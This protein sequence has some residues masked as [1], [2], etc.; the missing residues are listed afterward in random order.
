MGQA[1]ALWDELL[2]ESRK[3]V[4]RAILGLIAVVLVAAAAYAKSQQDNDVSVPVVVAACLV[5]LIIGPVAGF[6]VGRRRTPS[7]P[8]SPESDR[9][10][11]EVTRMAR[12][13]EVYAAHIIQ[14][15]STI[16]ELESGGLGEVR[17]NDF[18][19]KGILEPA[20]DALIDEAGEDVRV[21]V[22]TPSEDEPAD[23]I[24]RWA[25]GH[26]IQGRQNYQ[27]P[28]GE[29]FAGIAYRTGEMQ[30]SND[31]HND[32]RFDPNPRAQPGREFSSIVVVP[33][34]LVARGEEAKGVLSVVSTLKS[35]FPQ[36][37][38]LYIQAVG[39]ALSLVCS[40]RGWNWREGE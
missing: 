27:R 37:D 25:A 34:S 23:F 16:Q 15:I 6:A 36:A 9:N 11:R 40:L 31:C 7:Q 33:V 3:W 21:S 17:M 26:T 5:L 12:L 18:V 28:I 24:M 20:R 30:W 8:P 2:S 39:V 19:E 10:F 14:I 22:L 29:T 38:L 35:A 4:A 13:H 1:R 32:H